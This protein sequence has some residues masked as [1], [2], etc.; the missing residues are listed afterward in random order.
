MAEEEPGREEA[1]E[2]YRKRENKIRLFHDKLVEFFNFLD[3]NCTHMPKTPCQHKP[4]LICLKSYS[5][6]LR[7]ISCKLYEA[8]F[9]PLLV[10]SIFVGD[11][12]KDSK[13]PSVI[14][15]EHAERFMQN[16]AKKKA[17][18]NKKSGIVDTKKTSKGQ[19]KLDLSDSTLGRLG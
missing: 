18:E 14:T 16:F 8:G 10:D 2:A 3:N 11:A 17:R 12:T 6:K 9:F 1:L 19:T 13:S 7:S 15:K 5:K 4:A